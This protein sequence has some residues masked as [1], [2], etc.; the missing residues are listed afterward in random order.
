MSSNGAGQQVK[1]SIPDTIYILGV[2]HTVEV[3]PFDESDADDSLAAGLYKAD[4]REIHID[5]TQPPH[6]YSDIFCHEVAEGINS[7]L[8]LGLKHHQLTGM[9]VGFHDVFRNQLTEEA[10]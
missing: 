2:L 4:G 1:F 9:A 5:S 8:D 3:R 10:E 7:M 6:L